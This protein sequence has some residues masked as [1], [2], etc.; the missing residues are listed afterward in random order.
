MRILCLFAITILIVSIAGCGGSNNAPIASLSGSPTPTPTPVPLSITTGNWT[1][2]ARSAITNQTIFPDVVLTPTA[3]GVAGIAH[4]GGSSCF[5]F[6]DQVPITGTLNGSSL[7]ISTDT[8]VNGQ[9]INAILSGSSTSLT[10][11]FTLNGGTCAAGD[12]GT[13]IGHLMPSLNGTWKGTL[14]STVTPTAPPITMTATLTQSDTPN[15]MGYLVLSGTVAFTG[16][17][18]FT[19]G[20]FIPTQ[21][22]SAGQALSLDIATDNAGDVSF[23]ALYDDTQSP[24]VINPAT[25]QINQGPCAGDTGNMILVRQ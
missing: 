18:C 20:T 23:G 5:S 3:T 12:H 15:S 25:Y 13:L 1:M 16:T 4:I 2:Q 8:P 6:L 10:G 14:T 24:N 7:A 21:T 19:N 17:T 11:S 9:T 22:L